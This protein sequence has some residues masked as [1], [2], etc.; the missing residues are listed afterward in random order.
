MPSLRATARAS[1]GRR[2]AI[3]VQAAVCLS[4]VAAPS[5][6]QQKSAQTRAVPLEVT[7]PASA[8]PWT[9]YKVDSQGSSWPQTEWRNFD[10]LARAGVSPAV[11][12]APSFNLPVEGDV[13]RGRTLAYDRSRGGSC[14]VCHI[15]GKSTPSQPGNVGPDLSTIGNSRDD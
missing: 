4:I 2:L 1:F 15:M 6:A 9:R 14:V 5:F 12:P 11:H 7:K 10:N 13:E 8:R 3:A